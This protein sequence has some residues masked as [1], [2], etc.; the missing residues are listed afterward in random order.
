MCFIFSVKQQALLPTCTT[1][2]QTPV[3]NVT[4]VVTMTSSNQL[5]TKFESISLTIYKVVNSEKLSSMITDCS[6][7][8]WKIDSTF[9]VKL[10]IVNDW[11]SNIYAASPE[12]L[13]HQSSEHGDYFF[14]LQIKFLILSRSHTP[15]VRF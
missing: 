11:Y 8:S 5:V 15:N 13:T 14:I 12:H 4:S 3:V 10:T 6:M 2:E 7:K 9:G 1:C